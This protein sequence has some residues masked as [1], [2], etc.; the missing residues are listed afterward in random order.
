VGP[1]PRARDWPVGFNGLDV[2]SNDEGSFALVHVSRRPLPLA[3]CITGLPPVPLF[4]VAAT[5]FRVS[6]R[7]A[8]GDRY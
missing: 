4:L 7:P 8:P 1:G 6:D 5:V 2:A 3:S